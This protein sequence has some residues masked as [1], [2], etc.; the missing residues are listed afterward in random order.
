MR[1]LAAVDL[2]G[3][4]KQH[5]D[6]IGRTKVLVHRRLEARGKRVV[7][8]NG[9][10]CWRDQT[11]RGVQALERGARVVQ[12]H[13]AVVQ[14]AAVVAAHDKKAH[15]LGV[16]LLEH[17]ADG[18][19]VAQRFGHLLVVDIDKAVVHPR[20]RKR[21]AGSAFA[22][23]DFVLVVRKL[24]I[25]AAA[26]DVKALAQQRA[27]HRRALDVP[28]RAARTP[29]AWPLHLVWLCGFGAFP[30]DEI[31]RI[32]FAVVA[33]LHGDALAGVE[34]IERFARQLA[35]AG[36]FAHRK[37]D[38]AIAGLISQAFALQRA[39]HR[40]HLR[41][42]VGGARLVRGAL[43]AQRVGILV[44]RVDHAV[45]QA[46]DGLAIGD[47]AL[48][49]LVVN[50]GDVAH[51]SNTQAT[52]LE[53]ALYHV[54]RNHRA[55]MAEVAQVIHRH[56]AHIH[57]HMARFERNE[58]FQSTRQRVVDTQG[59]GSHLEKRKKTG[60]MAREIKRG[61]CG[62]AGAA[63]CRPMALSARAARRWNGYSAQ[64]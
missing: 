49:D 56:A 10:F 48:D 23:G 9:Q 18:E 51:I 36:E 37:V 26:V 16:V 6:G 55:R 46:T 40:Q 54:K 20:L 5:G 12:M 25:G 32:V 21:L 45:G 24:Q 41:H 39:N 30:Q 42:V 2:A 7:P 52:G 13:I 11:E 17:V 53:P 33:A 3:Q 59:H 44:Q 50:V 60:A 58:V 28:A 61:G 47:G 35:V 62:R 63:Q 8:V 31:Q 19:E 1:R 38:V 64:P 27:A 43:D 22:L 14:R 4:V 15:R 34:F 57:A 29:C